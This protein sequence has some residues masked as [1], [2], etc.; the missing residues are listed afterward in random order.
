MKTKL[1]IF[2]AL[3]AAMLTFTAESCFVSTKTVEVPVR[4]EGDLEFH[5]TGTSDSKTEILDFTSLME[6]LESDS[7]FDSLLSANIENGYWRVTRNLG[8]ASTVL[9]GYLNVQREGSAAPAV[10]LISYTSINIADVS[11]EF[12]VAPLDPAGVSLLNAGFD[13]YLQAKALGTTLPNLRFVFS[14]TSSATPAPVD[15]YW[16]GKVK[17]ILVGLTTVDVPEL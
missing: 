12:V 6:D 1:L 11:G 7:A 2:L 15:F 9:T 8:S 17:F 13:Q 16:E 5:T 14:W 4:G 3:A 10:P